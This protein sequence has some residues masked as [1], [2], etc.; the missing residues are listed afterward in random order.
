MKMNL[1]EWKKYQTLTMREELKSQMKDGFDFTNHFLFSEDAL[2]EMRQEALIE[3]F[4]EVVEFDDE[5][6]IDVPLIEKHT[7]VQE[8]FDFA[9]DQDGSV[10]DLVFEFDLSVMDPSVKSLT[11]LK[12][13]LFAEDYEMEI[14]HSDKDDETVTEDRAKVIFKRSKGEIKKKKICGPGMRLAGN[15]C[16]P[17][18]GTQKAKERRKGIKLKRAKKAMGSGKKKKAAL[19]GRITKRRVKGRSRA[20]GNTIN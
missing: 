12:E 8:V 10:M 2:E 1:I 5:F 9:P 7:E 11:A 17:Q 20:L 19:R 15:R 13:L 4:D 6:E 16:I 14:I 3:S 18:T